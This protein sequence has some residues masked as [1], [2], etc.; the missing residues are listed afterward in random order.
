MG[1]KGDRLTNDASISSELLIDKLPSIEGITSK[2]MFGGYGIFHD[3]KMFSL[4]N[5]KGEIYLKADDTIVSKF[6]DAGATQHGKM[7]YFSLP[8]SVLLDQEIL[9]LW[10]K[11]SIDI[12]K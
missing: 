5:S 3:G 8:K 2:K 11:E 4:V 7:P 1:T 9:V 12:S 6:E 10:A